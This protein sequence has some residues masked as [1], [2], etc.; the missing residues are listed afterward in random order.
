MFL[1]LVQSSS[2][3]CCL[4]SVVM[5]ALLFYFSIVQSILRC[6]VVVVNSKTLL[7]RIIPLCPEWPSHVL[8]VVLVLALF[9]WNSV[10]LVLEQ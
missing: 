7:L 10:D 5:L 2:F 4:L 3:L 9:L 8:K 1:L 6:G